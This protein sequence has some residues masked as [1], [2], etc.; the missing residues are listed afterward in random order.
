MSGRRRQLLLLDPAKASRRQC[1]EW[2]QDDYSTRSMDTGQSCHVNLEVAA[3][4]STTSEASDCLL[5]LKFGRDPD[6]RGPD[7]I[8]LHGQKK[9]QGCSSVGQQETATDLQGPAARFAGPQGCMVH[10]L[11]SL[12]L[13]SGLS[14]CLH[15]AI[16]ADRAFRIYHLLNF[17][18]ITI[19]CLGSAF[20]HAG[21]LLGSPLQ[22]VH[23]IAAASCKVFD[24]MAAVHQVPGRAFAECSGQ[25]QAGSRGSF[26]DQGCSE[27]GLHCGG[28]SACAIPCCI[29]SAG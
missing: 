5:W 16:H 27:P 26:Q 9:P 28:S 1:Q 7:D 22:A 8:V 2:A 4:C 23:E 15:A 19:T 18:R 24:P 3:G 10:L 17:R 6:G 21:G 13:S 29:V 12:F 11:S 14:S 25:L 20:V